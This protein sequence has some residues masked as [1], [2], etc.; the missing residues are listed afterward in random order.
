MDNTAVIFCFGS[1]TR[2]VCLVFITAPPFGI[3]NQFL[4][5]VHQHLDPALFGTD[6]NALIAHATDHVKRIPGLSAKGKLQGV[7]LNALFQGLFKGRVDLKKPVGRTQPA[8]ALVR[9]LVII[10]F[11]PKRDPRRGILVAGKLGPLKKLGQDALPEAF[12]FAQRHGMMGRRSDVLDPVF[13]KLLFKPGSASPIGVLTPVV[14]EHL[15]GHSVFANGPTVGLDHVFGRLAAV[16][17]QSGDIAAV[18]V[19]KPDQ[20]GVLSGQP[21]GHNIALPHLVGPGPLKKPGLGR[22]FLTLWFWRLG[23]ALIAQG[24]LNGRCTGAQPEKPLEDIADA[25]RTVSGICLFQ[26]NDGLADCLGQLGSGRR[27]RIVYQPLFTMLAVPFA[28]GVDTVIA[29]AEL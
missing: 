27:F 20:I 9:P 11:C 16:K 15:F 2:R 24:A 17:P 5:V 1:N 25:P 7:F 14:G 10:K 21:E 12:D 26:I 8:D 28:P 18:V 3:V 29:D 4:V 22:V 19:D 13:G 6:H 23:Q